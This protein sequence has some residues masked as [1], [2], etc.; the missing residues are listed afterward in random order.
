MEMGGSAADCVALMR[1]WWTKRRARERSSLAH[2]LRI[3]EPLDDAEKITTIIL[4]ALK[5]TGQRGII[6]RGW[7]NL[8][9]LY[10]TDAVS[11]VPVDVY[12]LGD[13]PHDWL[14]PQC[15]AVV[16]HGGA[17]TTASGLRAGN[18]VNDHCHRCCVVNHWSALIDHWERRGFWRQ[19]RRRGEEI[20][21]GD[22]GLAP[23]LD[24]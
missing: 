10:T 1:L 9:V 4:K 16:H 13:C 18:F 21:A 17:G 19:P 11:E 23:T 2:R 22:A 20:L 5:E 12:L 6:S 7:G 14:F 15:S 8:G 3:V 24:S